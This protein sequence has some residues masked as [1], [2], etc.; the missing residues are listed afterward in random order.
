MSKPPKAI[1]TSEFRS[2]ALPNLRA[3]I[4]SIENL[5]LLIG[6]IAHFDIVVD[7]NILISEVLWHVTKRRSED[8]RTKLQECID[9]GTFSA[10]ATPEVVLEVK[11]KILLLS[12]ER[13]LDHGACLAIWAEYERRLTIQAASTKSIQKYIFGQDPDDAPTL[14]LADDIQAAGIYSHDT[15]I[16]AMGGNTLSIRFIAEA[17]DYSRDATISASLQ[18][19]NCL[20]VLSTQAV[21]TGIVEAVKGLLQFIGRLPPEIKAI[22]FIGAAIAFINP[23]IRV[24]MSQKFGTAVNNTGRVAAELLSAY[25]ATASAAEAH[26][27]KPLLPPTR[28]NHKS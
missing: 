25:A 8:A 15:D 24:A 21:I 27:P 2:D 17:R 4:D 11:E 6:P 18:I 9:A 16:H 3:L 19:G 20:I 23:K 5:R 12:V 26:K 22:A 10:F 7:A 13:N 1:D 28:S 14:A